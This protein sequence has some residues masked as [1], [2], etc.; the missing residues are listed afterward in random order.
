[1]DETGQVLEPP[2]IE[3]SHPELDYNRDDLN[4]ETDAAETLAAAV[5]APIP[6]GFKVCDSQ[7]LATASS[8]RAK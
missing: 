8:K 3:G 6:E 7:L 4:C 1:M 2:R 5:S